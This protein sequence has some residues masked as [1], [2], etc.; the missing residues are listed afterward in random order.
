MSDRSHLKQRT[1]WPTL[2]AVQTLYLVRTK[3]PLLCNTTEEKD[4]QSLYM[5]IRIFAVMFISKQFRTAEVVWAFGFLSK[6]VLSGFKRQHWFSNLVSNIQIWKSFS[7]ILHTCITYLC[8][9]M[10]MLL[11]WDAGWKVRVDQREFSFPVSTTH[12]GRAERTTFLSPVLCLVWSAA[13]GCGT[14]QI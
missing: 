11:A 9:K 6:S 10:E 5:N 3:F 12:Y 8:F 1:Y 13:G 4:V 14:T 7:S 2:W